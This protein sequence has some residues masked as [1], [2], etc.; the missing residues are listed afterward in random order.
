MVTSPMTLF[1]QLSKIMATGKRQIRRF[2]R[3]H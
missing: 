1:L 2:R 3:P